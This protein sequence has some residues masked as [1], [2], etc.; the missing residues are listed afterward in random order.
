MGIRHNL[1]LAGA[2]ACLLAACSPLGQ[3]NNEPTALERGVESTGNFLS[4]PFGLRSRFGRSQPA[5][6][7]IP[8]TL[9][10]PIAVA[11]IPQAPVLAPAAP[12]PVF[13]ASGAV[14]R[15]LSTPMVLGSQEALR[16]VGTTERNIIVDYRPS[17]VDYVLMRR[18]VDRVCGQA[19]PNER[20]VLAS[21]HAFNAVGFQHSQ[22]AAQAAQIASSQ[23]VIGTGGAVDV[24]RANF[25]C[26]A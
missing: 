19:Y 25:T 5:D 13:T 17:A 21:I 26:Q 16:T 12:S 7:V 4:D 22:Q 1:I 14:G 18:Q 20:A 23:S 10:Q 2:T 15:L 8:E 11:P 9:D 3:T 6:P 24:L